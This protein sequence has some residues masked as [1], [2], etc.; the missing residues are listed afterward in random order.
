MLAEFAEWFG[1]QSAINQ[2]RI[3]A[4]LE[5]IY[6]IQNCFGYVESLKMTI[7]KYKAENEQLRQQTGVTERLIIAKQKIKE[8]QIKIE[9]LE[10]RQV[11]VDSLY[12][13][14]PDK[15]RKMMKQRIVASY[16]YKNIVTKNKQL[17]AMLKKK[18]ETN[19]ELV[20]KIVQLQKSNLIA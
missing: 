10:K 4:K 1:N 18:E 5:E 9:E 11:S 16:L 6:S 7:E 13:H 3:L 20:S 14:L 17:K 15:E 2:K 19:S 8:L 12:I